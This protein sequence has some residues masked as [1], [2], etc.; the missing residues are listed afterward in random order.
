MYS[1]GFKYTA[2]TYKDDINFKNYY[3]ELTIRDKSCSKFYRIFAISYYLKKPTCTEFFNP[4]F[5]Q[6]NITD[7]KF[8]E[9]FKKNLPEYILYE[10]EFIFI[11]KKGE[12]QQDSLIKGIPNVE[13]FIKKNYI[14]YEKYLD[15]WIILKKNKIK[16]CL[17]L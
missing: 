13:K 15:K 14:F 16:L 11:N 9:S 17:F 5:I 8:L 1:Y 10:Q 7:K 4:Q 6:H 2:K 12:K 3:E